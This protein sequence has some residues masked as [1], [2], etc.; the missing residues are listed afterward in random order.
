MKAET[1]INRLAAKQWTKHICIPNFT[2]A[3]WWEC[4][5]AEFT[6]GGRFTEFEVKMSRSDFMADS[7]K[8][9]D[10]FFKEG[11]ALTKHQALSIGHKDGPN[12]FWF[13]TMQGIVTA[14]EVPQ[15]A[16]WMEFNK[17]GGITERK[18]APKLHSHKRDME[19]ITRSMQCFYYR[20]WNLRRKNQQ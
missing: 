6:E 11:P 2:P 3:H 20:Y 10:L 14:N 17:L 7:R 18:D 15:W 1:I 5:L 12:H 8:T 19:R 13:V 9:D 16:G 4:D